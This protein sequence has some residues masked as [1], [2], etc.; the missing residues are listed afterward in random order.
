MPSSSSELARCT[1]LERWRTR[2]SVP[3]RL[4]IPLKG[5]TFYENPFHVD[6]HCAND[7]PHAM[8]HRRRTPPLGRAGRRMPR[9]AD[10]GARRDDRERR[11][12]ADAVRAALLPGEPHLGDRR[13]HDRV[14]LLPA[15][16]GPDRRPRRPQARVP[17]RARAVRRRLRRLRA[18]AGPDDADRGALRAGPRRRGRL[19][20]DPRADRHRVPRA[21]GARDGDERLH[22]HRLQRRLDR[23]ARRRLADR[24][25]RLALDLLH[26]PADRPRGVPARA[27]A[28]RGVPAH[29]AAPRRRLARRAADDRR[30]RARGLR[31][32]DRGRARLGLRAHARLVRRRARA[33]GAVRRARVAPPRPDLPAADPARARA[34]GLQ[35]RPRP[36][37]HRHVLDL[38]ARLAVSAAGARLRRAGDRARVPADDADDG[39]DVARPGRAAA[40]ARR[41]GADA[42]RRALD[43]RAGAREPLDARAPARRTFRTC[44]CRSCCSGSAPA[45]R[46]CR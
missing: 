5:T 26:Q 31:D 43:D 22:L 42:D 29:R 12:A 25:A 8:A 1:A 15:A 33:A 24:G 37:D 46:S 18:G 16:G 21:P 30:D 41:P 19:R 17:R 20:R 45:R 39:R 6:H 28:D 13:L 3:G 2:A 38:R 35:R 9:T 4:G 44:C 11:A 14:R 10:G 34:D 36:A 7:D 27:R 23:A 40:G 32:R